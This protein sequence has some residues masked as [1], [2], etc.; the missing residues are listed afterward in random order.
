MRTASSLALKKNLLLRFT[1]EE[2]RTVHRVIVP[3]ERII[4]WGSW[5]G[6]GEEAALVGNNGLMLQFH[7]DRF[8][9]LTS[10]TN[11]HLRCASY[12]PKDSTILAVG[13]KGTII[14]MDKVG[15]ARKLDSKTASNLRRASWSPDGSYAIIVG[16]DGAALVWDG[17]SFVEINGALNNL[18]SITWDQEGS[19]Y[20][21]GNYFGPSMTPSPT[22]YKLDYE[23]KL[24]Q[25]V[26]ITE[27]TDIIS[28]D[29]GPEQ[30][31]LAV[32]YDLV[33]QEPRAYKWNGQ[34]LESVKV[35]EAGVYPTSVA[36]QPGNRFAFVGTG[37]PK[38]SGQ[39]G[40]MVLGYTVE[41]GIKG[42]L[43]EDPEQR[44]VCVAWRPQSDYA[45]IIGNRY[46]RTF[47]T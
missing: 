24:L 32:G 21:S 7:N 11:E 29:F 44:I 10:Q 34:A 35:D 19:A 45:L 30:Q 41:D 37:T 15:R 18:R 42:R 25:S 3:S 22:L 38:P 36:W 2:Q 28:I 13:N 23:A 9:E 12:N 8:H 31:L 1:D 46:A 43:F 17:L 33:W 14:L 26:A 47:S 5:S 39:G 20:V 6:D 4:R 40:G 27:K 16:N